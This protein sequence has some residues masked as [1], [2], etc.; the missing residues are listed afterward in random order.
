LPT[1]RPSSL[2]PRTIA[3]AIALGFA[4][5]GNVQAD[6]AKDADYRAALVALAE[7]KPD[8]AVVRLDALLGSPV[9][10]QLTAAEKKRAE[11]LHLEANVRSGE[12]RSALESPLTA[13]AESD[14]SASFWIALAEAGSGE[15][16]SA[17][18][19]LESLQDLS[20]AKFR[21][22][23]EAA[24]T[25]CHLLHRLRADA[26]AL[27]ELQR[28]ISNVSTTHPEMV[29]QAIVAM[30]R[31][32]LIAGNTS[33]AEAAMA[34][35]STTSADYVGAWVALEKGLTGDAIARFQEILAIPANKLAP[36]MADGARHGLATARLNAGEEDTAR[37]LWVG[38]LENSPDSPIAT[39]AM[40]YLNRRPLGDTPPVA[41][42]LSE[43]RTND[44]SPHRQGLALWHLAQSKFTRGDDA[45]GRSLLLEFL[46]DFPGHDVELAVRMRLA[47]SL[48]SIREFE[49]ARQML[50]TAA[51]L[52]VN[53][54]DLD[55]LD[56]LR[57][58]IEFYAG[59][60]VDAV[61][62]FGSAVRDDD[63]NLSSSANF[64][65]GQAR[66]YGDPDIAIADV[67]ANYDDL[68]PAGSTPTDLLL[69]RGFHLA[70]RGSA[71]AF[72]VL[73]E[74]VHNH[75][76]HPRAADAELALAELHLNQIP[77]K[78]VSAREHI[79]SA[80]RRNLT[81]DQREQID[82]VA[83]WI[84]DSAGEERRVIAL[85]EQFLNDWPE[86][87]L[88]PDVLMKLGETHYQL[89]NFYSSSRTFQRLTEEAPDS[90]L[91]PAAEFFAAKAAGQS[92]DPNEQNRAV[93]LWR[94]LMDG[95]TPFASAAR[96]ELGLLQ[97]RLDDVDGALGSFQAIL[98][99]QPPPDDDLRF[100]VLCDLGQ[101]WFAKS[102]ANVAANSESEIDFTNAVAA[103]D[104]LLNSENASPAWKI[105]AAVRKAKC[106]ALSERTEEALAIYQTILADRDQPIV[107]SSSVEAEEWYYRAGFAAIRVFE[108]RSDW[109]EAVAVADRLARRGGVRSVEAGQLADRLRLE[110]FVWDR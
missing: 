102:N 101:A 60:I 3:A 47:Q 106:L 33:S 88:R 107:G 2:Y 13:V 40:Q 79:E 26:A 10:D 21:Y 76:D 57:G 37:E 48:I 96:H 30:A 7:G 64:N 86:S 97:L 35:L 89:G 81:I 44:T 25:R 17:A 32:H 74:F 62:S 50:E 14:P 77:P 41:E 61:A 19:R 28:F 20:A 72:A 15:L 63:E 27:A 75:E 69:E 67:L 24:L 53:P 6:L 38:L 34:E 55:Q 16:A 104:Q 94:E 110:H 70:R 103:F 1:F 5:L 78:S 93:G 39:V 95:G 65:V 73:A 42:K 91:V 49:L 98:D 46:S 51:T 58:Q 92:L 22:R 23:N 36:V 54:V 105:Q 59:D 43:W 100:A 68:V 82:H 108:S 56:F 29:T 85:A 45:R 71:A 31:I 52:A 84:E 83:M 12:Y 99:M 87:K 66:L 109:K 11:L 8:I 90:D 4:G 18:A 80:K 9:A